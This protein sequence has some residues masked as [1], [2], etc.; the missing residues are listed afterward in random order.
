MLRNILI[1]LA[2]DLKV[3]TV[4]KYLGIYIDELKFCDHIAERNQ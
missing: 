1:R 2:N 3:S 4:E